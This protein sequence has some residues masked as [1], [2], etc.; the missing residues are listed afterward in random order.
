MWIIALVKCSIFLEWNSIFVPVGK[1]TYF[2]W[3]CY[4][5]CTA[6]TALSI[7]LFIVDM[8]NCTPFPHNWDPL[9]PG[10]C[11][12]GIAQ[13]AIASAATNAALDLIPLILAQRVIWGLHMAWN[14]KLGVSLIF[15]VGLT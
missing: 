14:K 12:L 3:T 10:F 4:A 9:V 7:V 2:T 1:R 13:M 8:V 6:V 11:R 15:L 5:L